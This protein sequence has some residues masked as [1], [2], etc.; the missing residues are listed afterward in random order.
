M[1]KILIRV[2]AVAS[3]ILLLP[4][5]AAYRLGIARFYYACQLL[6]LIPGNAG[7]LIRRVWYRQTLE[8]CGKGFAIGF[9]SVVKCPETR[10]GNHVRVGMGCMITL[11][12]IGDYVLFSDH[13]KIPSGRRQHDIDNREIPI[14]HQPSRRERVTIGNDVWLGMGAIVGSDVQPGCVVG[15]GSVVTKTFPEYTI[16]AGVPGRVIRERGMPAEPTQDHAE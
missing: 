14:I 16:I 10:I 11:A 1:R 5:L 2:G 9:L 6:S 4:L 3:Y 7:E 8:T 13:V 12:D 15:S